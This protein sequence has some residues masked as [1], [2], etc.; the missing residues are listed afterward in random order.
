MQIR[1]LKQCAGYFK[2]DS[3]VLFPTDTVAGIGCRFDSADG[4]ARI[5][6]IK[7]I[8]EK[9]PM[10]V[11]I[12]SREQLDILKVRKSRLSNLL[13]ERFWPG[14]LTIVLTSEET[15]PCS[16]D[17]NSL[18]LRMPDADVL[19]KIIEMVGVPIAAT[20]ANVHGKPPTARLTDVDGSVKRKVDHMIEFDIT[21][22]GLPSTVVRI[23]GGLPKI[24]REG[25]VTKLEIFDLSGNEFGQ[26]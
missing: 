19:R 14:G 5:R 4:I 3:V 16:G 24:Q 9:S 6:K 26:R 7:G 25:S 12:S 23:E 21:P 20:S 10:A 17:G 15:F 18:G 2:K 13:M 11:L 8:D 22:N 1:N